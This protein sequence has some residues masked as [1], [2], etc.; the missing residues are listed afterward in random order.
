MDRAAV[1]AVNRLGEHSE[2]FQEAALLEIQAVH[3]AA[4]ATD[5]EVAAHGV[6]HHVA[7]HARDA[8]L[9]VSAELCVQL[10]NRVQAVPQLV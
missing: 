6:V 3:L 10:C 1:K 2:G 5:D 4:A 7:T 8:C 9:V